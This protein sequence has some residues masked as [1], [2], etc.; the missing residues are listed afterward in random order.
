MANDMA[1]GK[2]MNSFYIPIV[3]FQDGNGRTG[4]IILFRGCLRH[5]I[6]PFIILDQAK[7]EYYA[8][9]NTNDTDRL[10]AFFIKEQ[11]E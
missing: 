4:R 6:L 3:P 5:R 9:L 10:E 8:A 1:I 11:I 7:A 2:S